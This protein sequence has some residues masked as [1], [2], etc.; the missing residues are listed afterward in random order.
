[1]P[2]LR[3]GQVIIQ[4]EGMEDRKRPKVDILLDPDDLC[5]D[6]D[7]VR[8]ALYSASVFIGNHLQRVTIH[9]FLEHGI[10][11]IDP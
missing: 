8:A 3:R 4:I 2:I 5:P 6:A 10:E 9:R 1:M 7:Q 11:E